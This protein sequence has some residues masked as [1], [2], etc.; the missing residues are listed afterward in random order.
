MKEIPSP[1]CLWI[2]LLLGGSLATPTVW[3]ASLGLNQLLQPLAYLDLSHTYDQYSAIIDLFIYA[4]VFVG[5]AQVSLARR[6]TGRGGRAICAGVGLALAIGMVIA[7]SQFDFSL[8]SFG[9]VAALVL[10]LVFGIMIFSL[11]HYAGISR[12]HSLAAAYLMI[13]VIMLGVAPEF[14]NWLSDTAPLLIL[15]ILGLL[16]AA[17]GSLMLSA[18]PIGGSRRIFDVGFRHAMADDPIHRWDRNMTGKEKRFIKHRLRPT[19]KKAYKEAKTVSHD[20]D[21]IEAEIRRHAGNPQHTPEIVKTIQATVP[22]IEDLKRMVGNLRSL[23]EKIK[24]LDTTLLSHKSRERG[25]EADAQ[26]RALLDK[27]MR[28]EIERLDLEKKAGQ[29]EDAMQHHVAEMT[30]HLAQAMTAI[31]ANQTDQALTAIHNAK[32]NQ[33]AIAELAHL[34]RKLEDYL[35]SL[36]KSDVRLE[37]G[38]TS[39]P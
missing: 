9:P 24:G 33:Q 10:V 28:D 20:L 39:P 36:T 12:I 13:F 1:K 23:H 30:Y 4:L 37:A 8:R 14:L 34:I 5:A 22:D 21:S 29:I 35:L 16:L 15:P 25:S 18:V 26:A 11:L 31:Q 2:A 3:A 6:Y 7:E 38:A 27:E 19:A 32:S 17:L